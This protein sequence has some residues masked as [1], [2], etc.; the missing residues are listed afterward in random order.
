MTSLNEAYV[1]EEFRVEQPVVIEV[2]QQISNNGTTQLNILSQDAQQIEEM[3]SVAISQKDNLINQLSTS[4]S[5]LNQDKLTLQSKINTL[6]TKRKKERTEKPV[7][8]QQCKINNNNKWFVTIGL[9][10]LVLLFT[11]TYT[12]NIIDTWLDNHG[13]DLFSRSDRMNELFLLVIQFII[14]IIIIRLVL[15]LA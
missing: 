11:S 7:L 4:N 3:C 14:S 9:A 12:I 15:Q 1:I 6:E 13:V 10:V 8:E 2:P 5:E